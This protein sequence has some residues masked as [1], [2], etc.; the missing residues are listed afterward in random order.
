VTGHAAIACTILADG[1]G[2][3][4]TAAQKQPGNRAARGGREGRRAEPG[5]AQAVRKGQQ[6]GLINKHGDNG[7]G[8]DDTDGMTLKSP[9]DPL[10]HDHTRPGI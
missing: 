3:G 9:G 7:Q 2:A 8:E 10:S 1:S 6:D 4:H 5:I